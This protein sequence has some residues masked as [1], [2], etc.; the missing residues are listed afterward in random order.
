[1]FFFVFSSFAGPME[2]TAVEESSVPVPALLPMTAPV[3]TT[4]TC[5]FNT[6]LV[7]ILLFM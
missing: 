6:Y 3:Q 5:P 1:M 7:H 4:N 2:S